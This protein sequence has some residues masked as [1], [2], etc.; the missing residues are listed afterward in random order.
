VKKLL[1]ILFFLVFAKSYSQQ[2]VQTYTDRCTGATYT[3]TVAANSSTVV[4]FYNK[5]RV[6]TSAEFTNGT[7]QAWL[8]ETYQWW[9]NLSPCSANQS[10][11]TNTQ[12]T[13][14]NTTSNASNAANN[15]TNNTSS[16]GTTNNTSSSNTGS[17]G[18][19]TNNSNTN[20]NDTSNGNS[21]SGSGSSDSGSSSDSSSSGSS[22]DSSGSSDNSSDSSSGDSSS[23]DSGGDGDGSSSDSSGGSE[24]DSGEE[25]GSSDNSESG[26]GDSG[27][28]DEGGSGDSD[29]KS[30]DSKD[31]E[32][33]E[34]DSKS[35]SEESESEETEEEVKEEESEEEKQDEESEE[36]DEESEEDSEEESDEEESDDE[37]SEEEEE[38]DSEEESDNEDEEEDDEDKKK[39]RN[40]AP[41]IV[42]ANLMTMQMI[43]GTISTAASFGISQSSLTGVDTYSLNAM[44]WSNLKQFMIGGGVSTVYFKYDRK[45]PYSVVD[46]STGESH[47]FG[48][49]MEKGSIWSIDSHNVNFMYM[50]GTTMGSYTYSQVYMGQKENFWK[51]FVGGYAATVSVINAFGQISNSTSITGFGTKPFNFQKLPRWSFSPMLAV[52]LPVKLYP[53]DLKVDPFNNFTYIVGMNTNF[54]LTQRFVANLGINTINN[55]DPIIPT[56]FAATIGAR[57]QFF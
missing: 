40:L 33:S 15:A 23:G 7:L 6:F 21:S 43:D 42:S 30:D 19:T 49:R 52:S 16:S 28:T 12:T 45:V 4:T 56:T 44:V 3:F 11:T 38:E 5:S 25:G 46:P 53:L 32:S 13:T 24:G 47:V 29:D 2:V 8:E 20:N 14:T 18:S 37:E 35:E 9:K 10:N 27:E 51:G 54:Q 31:N 48:Y 1:F 36:S 57:F 17:S 50:F 41:P 34:E 39:K 55:T 26:E 22:S